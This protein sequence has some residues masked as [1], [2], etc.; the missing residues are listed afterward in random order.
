MK[1]PYYKLWIDNDDTRDIT[2]FVES[3]VYEDTMDEDNLLNITL[4]S[5]FSLQLADDS[6]F[7]TGQIIAFKFGYIG[8]EV[9]QVHRARITDISRKYRERVTMT[10]KCLDLGTKV[11]KVSNGGKI[12][13][14]K[15]SSE[16]AKEIADKFSLELEADTTS[17][18]WESLP[19]GN[20]DDLEFL[21]YLASREESGAYEVYIR[22]TTLYFVKRGIGRDSLLT[23]TYGDGDSGI[24]SFEPSIKESGQKPESSKST[25]AMVDSL[26]AKANNVV[27]DANSE[28][29][30]GTLGTIKR[31]YDENA[32]EIKGEGEVGKTIVSPV[33]DD[34]EAK[35]IAN[36]A[37]KKATLKSQV[38]KLVME[39]TP[40]LTPNNVI[41]IKNV[42]KSDAGNWLIN[43]VSHSI[44]PSGYT[45]SMDLTKN[46]NKRKLTQNAPKAE[47][48]NDTV[49]S[50]SIKSEVKLR[51]YNENADFLGYSSDNQNAAKSSPS[52]KTK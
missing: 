5:K 18:K 52:D 51:V 4:S 7:I 49:G 11:K 27:V 23:V 42:A 6:D 38:A 43:K 45:C 14:D 21:R 8:G 13:S 17:K 22:N 37:K 2:E 15:T 19:Q 41:T 44:S 33:Q 1:A 3:F 46:G 16:I 20:M 47:D 12:W 31:T 39:G 50:D 25:V 30:T 29:K 26:K 10:V 28:D 36:T 48:A 24:I 40:R 35:A 32:V 34:V 9:S